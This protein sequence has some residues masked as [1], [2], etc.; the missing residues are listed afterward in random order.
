M[1]RLKSQTLPAVFVLGLSVLCSTNCYAKQL[2]GVATP[3][4]AIAAELN[5][6]DM[7][8]LAIVRDKIKIL[9]GESLEQ[10]LDNLV[11][12]EWFTQTGPRGIVLGRDRFPIEPEVGEHITSQLANNRRFLKAYQELNALPN[13]A[14]SELVNAQ[15]KKSLAE[16]ERLFAQFRKEYDASYPLDVQAKSGRSFV[17]SPPFTSGTEQIRTVVGYRFQIL[18]LVELAGSLNLRDAGPS[19]LQVAKIAAQQYETLKDADRLHQFYRLT[20]LS[21]AS[22]YN[23]Q[24][25]SLGLVRTVLPSTDPIGQRFSAKINAEKLSQFDCRATRFEP[26]ALIGTVDVEYPAKPQQLSYMSN[27]S[28]SDFKRIFDAASRK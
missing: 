11:A 13:S 1:I 12:G 14:A 16:Y 7:T 23:R 10:S 26:H 18:S 19:V 15:L 27:L 6:A 24:I 25:L 2:P 28:D 4:G 5:P 8:Q 22:L 20:L 21:N 3:S 17:A 9:K